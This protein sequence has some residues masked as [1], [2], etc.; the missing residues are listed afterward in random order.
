MPARPDHSGHPMTQHPGEP[1]TQPESDVF[2][3]G[4][5]KRRQRREL[6]VVA[7]IALGGGL[8]SVVRYLIGAA[9]PV[10]A[11]RFPWAT[12]LINLSG[13]F[14]LGILMIF[15][16]DFWP[17]R[18][19]LRPFAGIGVLGGFTTF[20]TFA[21]ELRGL[22]SRHQWALTDAYA[23]SSLVGGI[24]AV[25]CGCALARFIGHRSQRQRRE[26]G[27]A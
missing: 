20:S 3:V 16:L 13:A 21:V 10:H 17:P 6:D 11:G 25:W 23:L 4:P 18:R 12:F 22:A 1:A 2:R 9:L 26:G 24:V 8:G 14:V 19:Y 7:V 15:V 5:P 27:G